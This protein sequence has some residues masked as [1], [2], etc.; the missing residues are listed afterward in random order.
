ML[1]PHLANIARELR[2]METPHKMCIRWANKLAKTEPN[3]NRR[4]WFKA[5]GFG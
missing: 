3:F 4:A 2:A 1:T 5:C